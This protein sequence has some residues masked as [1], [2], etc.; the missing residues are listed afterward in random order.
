MSKFFSKNGF[1]LIEV[2][3][4]AVVLGFLI[5]GLTRLQ[6]G[7][8]EAILR[9]RDRDAANFVAQHVLDSISAGGMKALEK[10]CNDDFVYKEDKYEYKFEGK[11]TGTNTKE[12]KVE[13]SCIKNQNG[14]VIAK[15]A[16]YTTKFTEANSQNGIDIISRS[17]EARVS[18]LY[19]SSTQSITMARVVK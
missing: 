15:E 16:D 1:G 12:Y 14:E 19:R 8:R 5:V 13:V 6:M 18:W 7:N 9:I 10:N 4:A 17:L 11:N 3:A 2:M